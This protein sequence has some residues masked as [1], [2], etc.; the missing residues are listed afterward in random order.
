MAETET[1][2]TT[3]VLWKDAIIAVLDENNVVVNCISGDEHF[4]RASGLDR[5]KHI[6][7]ANCVIGCVYNANLDSFMHLD[8]SNTKSFSNDGKMYTWNAETDRYEERVE[9]SEPEE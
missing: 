4:L 3:E 6:F 7:A 5:S 8:H 2:V 1:V 9:E